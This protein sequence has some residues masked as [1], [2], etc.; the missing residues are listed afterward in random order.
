M[1]LIYH[2]EA[3]A[4]IVEAIQF[5]RSRSPELADRFLRAFESAIEMIEE[6]PL[7]WATI[8]GDLRRILLRRFPYGIY[9]RVEDQELRVLIVKHHRRHPD[10]GMDRLDS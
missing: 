7:R 2:P 8:R 4:E 3:E 5:Y 6:N 10:H 9:Y 1:H